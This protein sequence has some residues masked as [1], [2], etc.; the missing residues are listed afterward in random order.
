M[1]SNFGPY[2]LTPDLPEKS[3]KRLYWIGRDWYERESGQI[4]GELGDDPEE[5]LSDK[6]LS[7]AIAMV[8]SWVMCGSD[9][10]QDEI[11]LRGDVP[12]FTIYSA[13]YLSYADV[14]DDWTLVDKEKDENT[15]RAE[16]TIACC[17]KEFAVEH[18][19][20]ADIYI[21]IKHIL[22]NKHLWK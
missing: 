17:R 22:E 18:G 6:G 7:G 10:F 15:D 1:H 3:R 16:R 21:D 14:E 13:E 4:I 5:S 12:I 11:Y 8:R 2:T 20:S 9:D 19:F